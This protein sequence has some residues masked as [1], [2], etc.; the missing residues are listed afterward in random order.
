MTPNGQEEEYKAVEDQE[1]EDGEAG[2]YM[3]LERLVKLIRNKDK[4]LNAVLS[5]YFAK[6]LSLL[7][8][9]K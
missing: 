3:L 2:Q 5:G 8:T 1:E 4:N 6:L 7:L 9:R